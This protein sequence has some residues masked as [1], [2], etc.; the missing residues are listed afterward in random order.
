MILPLTLVVV[1][2]VILVLLLYLEG[3][4]YSS[5]G[6]MR[7]EDLAGRTRPVDIEAFRNLIDPKEE[8]FLRANLRSREF[9]S[10]QRERARSAL[11]Y[12][13]NTTH[14]AACLLQLGE[15]AARN[16]DPRIALAGRQLVDSAL[17]LRTY[18]LLCMA[19]LCLR[20]A[21]PGAQFSYGR[22]ADNYQ[23]LS[24]LASQLALMQHPT[25]AARLSVLL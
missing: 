24:G 2:L 21:L 12:I 20:M 13:R 4:H 22:V 16:G 18:A 17:Q 7:M 1:A 25:K 19:Q 11:G 8:A 9:R 23:H 3:S 15:A 14:N 10:I 6:R 5:A